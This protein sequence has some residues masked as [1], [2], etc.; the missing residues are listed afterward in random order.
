LKN[1]RLHLTVAGVVQF[2]VLH[3]D[4]LWLL[5]TDDLKNGNDN[6]TMRN[7]NNLYNYINAKCQLNMHEFNFKENPYFI[8]YIPS[9]AAKSVLL[10][11]QL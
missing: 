9:L 10:I 3:Q 2:P 1:E 4:V 7:Y 5:D 8:G 11:M 6:T